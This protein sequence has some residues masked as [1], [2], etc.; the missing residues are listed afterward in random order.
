MIKPGH[1]LGTGN[2]EV[3][4]GLNPATFTKYE[5]WIVTEIEQGFVHVQYNNPKTLNAYGER[6][7]RD[8]FEILIALDND[9]DTNIILISSAVPKA[10]SSGLNLKESAQL[11]AGKE[12]WPLEARQKFLYKHVIDFQDAITYPARMK[13]PTIAL[14][15]GISYGL[16]LDIASACSIRVAVEGTKFSVRE[17]KVGLVADMGSLQRMTNLVGNKSK[18]YQYALTGEV[19]SAQ[20]SL[21]IGFVSKVV[22]DLASGVE[23]CTELGQDINQN[24]Q[25]VIKGTKTSIQQMVDGGSHERGLADVAVYNAINLAGGPVTLDFGKAKL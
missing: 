15:N 14:L 1:F 13:T 6:D 11:L 20:D 3:K 7:W 24:M 22:P 4:M 16:A 9:P 12:E 5:K 19:F 25:W 23:Y 21:E 8:Y 18:M 10:F 2:S 17:I